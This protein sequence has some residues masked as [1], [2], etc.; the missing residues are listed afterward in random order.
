MA[1][2]QDVGDIAILVHVPDA[3]ATAPFTIC[4]EFEVII[5]PSGRMS[6]SS[7]ELSDILQNRVELGE[8]VIGLSMFVMT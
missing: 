6:D 8:Y 5:S 3:A 4:S 1:C 2:H 7:R